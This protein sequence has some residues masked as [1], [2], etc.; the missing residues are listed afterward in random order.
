MGQ[1]AGVKPALLYS[2]GRLNRRFDTCVPDMPQSFFLMT[3]KQVL[4]FT[5]TRRLVLDS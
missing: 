4:R 5:H 1:V 2:P 3:N